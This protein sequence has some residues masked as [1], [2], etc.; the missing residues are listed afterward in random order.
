M[1]CSEPT[2]LEPITAKKKKIIQIP[3]GLH[4]FESIKTYALVSK[5]KESPFLWLEAQD[6]PAV[7]FLLMP[8]SLLFPTYQPEISQEDVRQLD[9]KGPGDAIVLGIVHLLPDGKETVNLRGPLIINRN[10]LIARQVVPIDGLHYHTQ[11]PLP[12]TRNN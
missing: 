9:L 5:P 3:M 10:T 6:N 1:K 4:G 11:H 7:K 2:V 12:V 8:P